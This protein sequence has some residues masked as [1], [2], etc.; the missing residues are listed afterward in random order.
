VDAASDKKLTRK[1]KMGQQEIVPLCMGIAFCVLGFLLMRNERVARWG[2]N[3]GRARIWIKLLG[4]ARALK[5]TRYVFGP[6]TLVIGL[7][8]VLIAFAH[9]HRA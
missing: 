6:F 3:R 1:K 9:G 8:C 7:L 2:L 4:E 5:L